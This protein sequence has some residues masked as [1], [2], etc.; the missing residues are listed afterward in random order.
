MTGLNLPPLLNGVESPSP[1]DTAI[2]QVRQQK[3]GAGDLFWSPAT[4]VAEFALILE[5]DVDHDKALEM[6]PLAMVALA[7]CLA[8]LLPPQVA[9][10]FRDLQ[11]LIVNGGIA[12]G[13][14]TAISKQ[15]SDW[16]VIAIRVG[17]GR[18]ESQSEPGEQPD[19]T[20]L[21]EEGWE[22]LDRSKFVE[23]FAR[24][25]LSWLAIWNDDGFAPIARAFRFKAEDKQ[26]PDLKL[27]DKNIARYESRL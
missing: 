4:D 8:I 22:D 12:G 7:D 19:I 6:V 2:F 14:A 18:T 20:T 21:D 16:L 9:I 15:Q 3:A 10:E 23:T 17:L 1:F 27:A 25:F 24:H 13:I 5:P 11:Q 26:D